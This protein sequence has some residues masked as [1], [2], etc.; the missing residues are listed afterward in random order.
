MSRIWASWETFSPAWAASAT[1]GPEMVMA[2]NAGISVISGASA[3]RKISSSR[4]MMNS[5]DRPW[6][7]LPVFP[8]WFCWLTAIGMAPARC[9]DRPDG[10]PARL[11]AVR[12][13]STRS[14]TAGEL[15]CET[16]DSTSIWTACPSVDRPRSRTSVTVFTW[17]RS[18]CR[19]PSQ[20]WSEAAS[21][22]LLR[23]ASTSTGTSFEP[24]NGLASV[25]ACSLGAL[26]GRKLALLPWVTLASE[27]R[28]CATATAATS[29]AAMMNQRNF[30]EKEPIPRKT[31]SICT[32]VRV[33]EVR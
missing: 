23:A 28:K 13:L 12:R 4:T 17:R 5:T 7:W 18:V 31:L 14:V 33:R 3:A 25:A 20:V 22:A 29:Q 11:I 30:T 32:R 16:L 19:V 24:P 8:V 27:G 10:G 9:T 26:A 15:P 2:R 1:S 6:I 21:G